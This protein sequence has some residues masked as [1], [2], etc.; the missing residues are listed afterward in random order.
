MSSG[1]CANIRYY[2]DALNIFEDSYTFKTGGIPCI[3]YTYIYIYILHNCVRLCLYIYNIYIIC[4]C[5]C[6]T[7]N[8]NMYI[9]HH[10]TPVIDAYDPINVLSQVKVAL[11]QTRLSRVRIEQARLNI[12]RAMSSS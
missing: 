8:E 2:E 6:V 5:V 11:L 3:Q 10:D 4:V 1:L 9:I 12:G 7:S